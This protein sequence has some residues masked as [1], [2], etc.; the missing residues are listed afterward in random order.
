MCGNEHSDPDLVAPSGE[1]V[2]STK[3][4]STN[5]LKKLKTCYKKLVKIF[6]KRGVAANIGLNIN[7]CRH[8][9]TFNMPVPIFTNSVAIVTVLLTLKAAKRTIRRSRFWQGCAAAGHGDLY[10]K[11]EMNDVEVVVVR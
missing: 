10:Y 6:L 3:S 8:L 2:L 4:G 1:R 5:L 7:K 9:M 11:L